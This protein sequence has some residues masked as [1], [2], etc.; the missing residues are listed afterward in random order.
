[1]NKGMQ[2]GGR[3]ESNNNKGFD[4]FN[5]FLKNTKKFIA[6]TLAETL[7]VMGIIGV[8]AA[9]TIP[10]L[11]SSTNDAEKVAKVKK[12]WAN[13]NEA[14]DRAQAVYGPSTSWF[15]SYYG[16]DVNE[17]VATRTAERITEFMKVQK[18]CG[19]KKVGCFSSKPLLLLN[20]EEMDSNYDEAISS[21]CYSLI[22]ADGTSLAFCPWHSYDLKIRIDIDGPNKGKNMLGA[23]IF[24]TTIDWNNGTGLPI[25][26]L[27]ICLENFGDF[28]GRS[29]EQYSS[30]GFA[31][32]LKNGNLDYLKCDGLNWDTKT[33][34]K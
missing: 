29:D 6:F 11:N 15:T 4:K 21:S 1:M 10:N 26:Q 5:S 25:N 3:V 17:H 18:V 27:N 22:L 9:L 28:D 33:S 14:F 32:I 16:A 19:Y 8:V 24:D 13:L 34:C 30:Y 20:G 2:L 7:I 12:I 31:W 23:D